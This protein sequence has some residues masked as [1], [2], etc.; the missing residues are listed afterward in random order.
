MTWI[1]GGFRHTTGFGIA[2]LITGESKF[3][4][5]VIGHLNSLSIIKFVQNIGVVIYANWYVDGFLLHLGGG[6][7][8]HRILG[9]LALATMQNA[10]KYTRPR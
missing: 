8:Y 5:L 1:F 10:K 7:H 2:H 3:N 6:I 4:K 9:C